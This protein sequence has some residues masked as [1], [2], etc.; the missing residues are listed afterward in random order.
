MEG[1]ENL[2]VE[3]AMHRAAVVDIVKVGYVDV[4]VAKLYGAQGVPRSVVC[5]ERCRG[6]E[7]TH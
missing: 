7:T 1:E 3:V 4:K 5:V 6:C 2:V